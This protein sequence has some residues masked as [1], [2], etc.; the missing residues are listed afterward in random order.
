MSSTVI[1]T[2]ISRKLDIV[3]RKGD[4]FILNLEVLDSEL[5]PFNLTN[6]KVKM[7]IVKSR[8]MRP[9]I[10]IYGNDYHEGLNFIINTEGLIAINVPS[11]ITET[12]KEGE[13]IYDISL[14]AIGLGGD[15][16]EVK[17]T[18]LNGKFIVNPDITI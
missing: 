15:I 4:T 13:Y 3:M 12:W 14:T 10:T 2:D 17:T 18:W 6:Y 9:L 5:S 8:A 1:N 11:S 16:E 7:S